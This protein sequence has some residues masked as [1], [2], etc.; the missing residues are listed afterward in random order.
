M[1]IKGGSGSRVPS[2]WSWLDNLGVMPLLVRR[3]KNIIVFINT[4]TRYAEHNADLQSLFV[5]VN[6]PGLSGDKR[7][8]VV[9]NQGLHDAVVGK[10]R[11]ARD[12]GDAQVYCDKDW[13]VLAN[14]R[15]GV[16]PYTGLNIC[17]V[18]N[19]IVPRWKKEFVKNPDV[20]QLARSFNN[21]PWFSTFEQNK[22]NVIKLKTPQ[23]NLL[24]NLSAWIIAN[25]QTAALVQST[26]SVLPC[27]QGVSCTQ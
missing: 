25:P 26:L 18:Y 15:F 9:F 7:N 14:A 6:P 23:V 3:V 22:P 27:P 4:E 5:P 10:L 1:P 20:L 2:G 13:E 16:R 8:N 12:R 24:S 21:F 19:A 11:E 17:F